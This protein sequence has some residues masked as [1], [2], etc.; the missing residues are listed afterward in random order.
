MDTVKEAVTKA[1]TNSASLLFPVFCFSHSPKL[2]N[3]CS[4]PISSPMIV[5]MARQSTTSMDFPL[6]I[7]PPSVESIPSIAPAIPI[8]NTLTPQALFNASCC[9]TRNN[10]PVKYPT[11]PP[12]IMLILFMMVPNPVMISPLLSFTETID[13]F[14]IFVYSFY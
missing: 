2:S 11:R 9:S 1:L 3:P 12:A 8:N 13:I 5:P 4:I 6:L 14:L 7:F 10:L